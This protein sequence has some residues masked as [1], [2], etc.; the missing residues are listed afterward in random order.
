M[1]FSLE[2]S[3]VAGGGLVLLGG[4]C[5]AQTARA[6]A[7]LLVVAVVPLIFG[8][9]QLSETVVWWGLGQGNPEVVRRSSLVFLFIALAFWPFWF[10]LTTALLEERPVWK[11]A[12]LLGALAS[13]AWF[14]ILYFPLLLGSKDVLEVRV[15]HHSIHYEYGT[16]P[17]YRYV[18]RGLLRVLY[19]VSVAAPLALGGKALRGGW[20]LGLLL[21]A[22][23]VTSV[24]LF[25]YAFISVWCFFAAGLSAYL[26]YMLHGLRRD[27]GTAGGENRFS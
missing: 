1:C 17:I 20:P 16:L 8:L 11:R 2:A 24:L 7:K 26:V 22:S 12:F 4:Y 10:P 14:W 13:T 25:D 3:L 9:Q 23:V 6:Q 21:L 19:F 15:E 5:V 27:I 18:P